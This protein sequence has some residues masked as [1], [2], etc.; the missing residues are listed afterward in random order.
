M[1][2]WLKTLAAIAPALAT[3]LGGPMAGVAV[4]LATDSLGIESNESALET[5]VL[6]GNPDVLLKL[7]Q[8]NHNF[9]LELKRLDVKLTEIS[10]E[11]RQSARELA[12]VDM[13]PQMVLSALYTLGFF[14]ILGLLISGEVTIPG[15]SKELGAMLFGVLTAGQIK[16]L[17]FWFGSSHGSKIKVSE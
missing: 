7:K 1:S 9:E 15:E 3:A 11:D 14:G 5:A 4:K 2:D 6:S 16:I 12:S 13:R 8:A 10:A 17:D